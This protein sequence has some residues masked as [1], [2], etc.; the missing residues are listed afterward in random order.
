M[1]LGLVFGFFGFLGFFGLVSMSCSPLPFVGSLAE[2]LLLPALLPPLPTS[3]GWAL[4]PEPTCGA[5][6]FCVCEPW[7]ALV[8]S[9]AACY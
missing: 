3:G 5:S 9:G 4:P 1:V 2:P 8:P 7:S 6:T